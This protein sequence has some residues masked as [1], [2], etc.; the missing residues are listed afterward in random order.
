MPHNKDVNATNV[1]EGERGKLSDMGV[2]SG[3]Q[4][5]DTVISDR[6]YWHLH[7]VGL[8]WKVLSSRR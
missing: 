2:V 4:H 5:R 1:R 8:S 6:M 7:V 3:D